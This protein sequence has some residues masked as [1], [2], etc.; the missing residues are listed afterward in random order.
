MPKIF[1]YGL[2]RIK[3]HLEPLIKKGL[4]SILVFGVID[5]LQKVYNFLKIILNFQNH[6]I[7]ICHS[8]CYSKLE[9]KNLDHFYKCL[10]PK[11]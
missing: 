2:N 4:S 10:S 7:Q 1:R 6:C 3:E 5:Q 8:K 11:I 9:I